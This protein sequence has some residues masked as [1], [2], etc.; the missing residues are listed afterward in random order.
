[1]ESERVIL[2]VCEMILHR[3]LYGSVKKRPLLSL[4]LLDAENRPKFSNT[5]K[6]NKT[7][8]YQKKN[9]KQF[10]TT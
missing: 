10:R 8:Q 4:L 2:C 3:F 5:L 6:K 9:Q 1:M 7:H